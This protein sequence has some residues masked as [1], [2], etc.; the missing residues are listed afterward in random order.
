MKPLSSSR[1]LILGGQ[2][3]AAQHSHV[4]EALSCAVLLCKH[5][6]F[7]ATYSHSFKLIPP[8]LSAP[9]P[10]ISGCYITISLC[11]MNRKPVSPSLQG[12]GF[13]SRRD[14]ASVPPMR[15]V[16]CTMGSSGGRPGSGYKA[17][18]EAHS[19]GHP[20]WVVSCGRCQREGKTRTCAQPSAHDTI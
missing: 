10:I 18:N 14:R 2:E 17:G 19:P 1:R 11:A 12:A 20:R 13:P 7:R 4:G 15:I 9:S 16:Q 5:T 3:E 6:S 8:S